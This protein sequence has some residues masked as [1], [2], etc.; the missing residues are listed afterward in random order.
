MVNNAGETLAKRLGAPGPE[1]LKHRGLF[2]LAVGI[3]AVSVFYVGSSGPAEAKDKAAPGPGSTVREDSSPNSA[4]PVE[5][6][7]RAPGYWT[8]QRSLAVVA[9]AIAVLFLGW[10]TWYDRWWNPRKFEREN[11]H[12]GEDF[13]ALLQA[14]ERKRDRAEWS[15]WITFMAL[16]VSY[17]LFIIQAFL[18]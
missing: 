8:P 10:K 5:E 7:E 13:E 4:A 17:I 15:A 1:G 16:A 12:A 2:V 18:P 11:E 3:L 14:A 9:N 6:T